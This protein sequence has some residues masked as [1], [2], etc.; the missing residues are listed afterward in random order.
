MAHISVDKTPRG[1]R[2]ILGG[3]I[4]LRDAAGIFAEF[5]EVLKQTGRDETI[6]VDTG[7]VTA[8]GLPFVQILIILQREA[9]VRGVAVDFISLMSPA[10]H[11]AIIDLGCHQYFPELF[12][13]RDVPPEEDLLS[14]CGISREGGV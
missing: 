11:E 9:F 13:G 2:I 10:V 4:S 12:A 5:H 6:L 14:L 7:S 8:A 3:D 1:F